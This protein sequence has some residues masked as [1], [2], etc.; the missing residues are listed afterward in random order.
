MA[1]SARHRPSTG[2]AILVICL[3]YVQPS[4]VPSSSAAALERYREGMRLLEQCCGGR[5]GGSSGGVGLRRRRGPDSEQLLAEAQ[6]AAMIAV[7]QD[8]SRWQ[9]RNLLGDVYLQQ[10]N[11]QGAAEEFL[12]TT[13]LDNQ[14]ASAFLKL[15]FAL[16]KM[17][18][19]EAKAEESRLIAARLNTDFADLDDE[20]NSRAPSRVR[21]VLDA[22]AAGGG[23]GS[24][25]GGVTVAAPPLGPPLAILI[26]YRDRAEHLSVLV[27][28]LSR[29][30][31]RQQQQ[32]HGNG[33]AGRPRG[34]KFKIFVVE[35]ANEKRWNKGIV[36][37]AGF[38]HIRRSHRYS[39]GAP[40]CFVFHDVDFI[41]QHRDIHYGCVSIPTHL[42]AAPSQYKQ[43]D[44]ALGDSTAD[45]KGN[46][47]G[48]GGAGAGAGVPYASF[49]GGVLSMS[50][51]SFVEMNGYS[52]RFWL[53][54]KEDDDL[55][56]RMIQSNTS[57]GKHKH[58][59]PTPKP[60][61]SSVINLLYYTPR[62]RFARADVCGACVYPMCGWMDG[63]MDP[64][65]V[66]QCQCRYCACDAPC[67][68]MVMR[69]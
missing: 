28:A 5:G 45:V 50:G 37:N 29:L 21:P 34:S 11:W 13:Q 27:P 18:G 43:Y 41:P 59:K 24:A 56:M 51:R 32:A 12:G 6:V 14:V 66:C 25:S 26:P 17:P 42:S 65:C 30:L 69:W 39:Y 61:Q 40:E 47:G 16:S 44:Y 54:G 62:H 7:E 55:Y 36:Y 60:C 23:A 22:D 10:Q 4:V 20:W 19:Y 58:A 68:A 9:H 38:D 2:P 31:R 8:P 33:K 35:Q 15:G 57:N 64:A 1:A 3:L 46:G 52:N 48:G 53:W 63:W 67:G 49:F